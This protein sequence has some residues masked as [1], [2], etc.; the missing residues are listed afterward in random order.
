MEVK[1]R[2]KQAEKE[3]GKLCCLHLIYSQSEL[4]KVLLNIYYPSVV[5]IKLNTA[6]LYLVCTPSLTIPSLPFLPFVLR[7]FII[8]L[9]THC[10]RLAFLHHFDWSVVSMYSG[11]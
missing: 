3:N 11:Q 7:Q 5:C 4:A 8:Y 2:I 10:A 1:G 9:Q 6:K